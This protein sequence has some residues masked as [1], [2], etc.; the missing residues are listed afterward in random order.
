MTNLTFPNFDIFLDSYEGDKFDLLSN[1]A[2]FLSLL[3][4]GHDLF[5]TQG[6]QATLETH[7]RTNEPI[8]KLV[9]R[10]FSF[11]FGD[12]KRAAVFENFNSLKHKD[13]LISF[14]N[15]SDLIPNSTDKI[16]VTTE[17]EWGRTMI[18][19]LSEY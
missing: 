12:T 3:L 1:A 14:Y 5:L 7:K 9:E 17:P 18:S 13:R 2:E 15:L 6:L 11:D 16:Q 4:T 19:L 8:L 10:H